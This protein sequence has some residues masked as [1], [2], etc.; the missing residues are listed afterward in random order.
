M[1][2]GDDSGDEDDDDDEARRD[3][4][5]DE[6][7]DGGQELPVRS[8]KSSYKDHTVDSAVLD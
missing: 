7:G 8:F 5:D 3:N 4:D 6:D 2:N 1:T